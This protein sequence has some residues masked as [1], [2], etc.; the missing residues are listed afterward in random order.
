MARRRRGS[1]CADEFFAD[2]WGV[3]VVTVPRFL[4]QVRRNFRT[5]Y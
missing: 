2:E 1:F 4:E 5:A 3:A